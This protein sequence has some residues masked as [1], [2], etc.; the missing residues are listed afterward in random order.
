MIAILL[1]SNKDGGPV[2]DMLL[3]FMTAYPHTGK[4]RD[5]DKDFLKSKTWCLKI[6][7]SAS[8]G[9]YALIGVCSS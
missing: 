1:F 8:K 3:Y 6:A 4:L 2:L 7:S 5:D 9:H